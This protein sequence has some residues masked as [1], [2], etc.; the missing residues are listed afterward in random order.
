MGLSFGEILVILIV[1]FFIVGPDKMPELGR[2][3]G[4]TVHDIKK[5][6]KDSDLNFKE[7]VDEIKKETGYSEVSSQV[8]EKEASYKK[9]LDALKKDLS[10]S[11]KDKK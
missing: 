5:S 3:L 4:K 10:F 6:L 2:T 1:A 11:S 8:K 7:E 9:D